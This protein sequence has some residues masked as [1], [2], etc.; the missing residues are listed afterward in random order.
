MTTGHPTLSISTDRG[1]I[2]QGRL[3]YILQVNSFPILQKN[4]RNLRFRFGLTQEEAAQL[5][6]L[7]HKH[8]QSIESGRRK[9]I[10]LE[11][12]DRIAAGFGLTSSDLLSDPL[13]TDTLVLER[14]PASSSAHYQKKR[15]TPYRTRKTDPKPKS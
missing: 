6:G 9:Q 12:V 8:Y 1:V 11:T 15:R 7:N 13:P 4:L 14:P 10:W 5:V 3:L 2:C